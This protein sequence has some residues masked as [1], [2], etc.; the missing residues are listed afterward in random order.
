MQCLASVSIYLAFLSSWKLACEE[1]GGHHRP[2]HHA[3]EARRLD[4]AL[5]NLTKD[6]ENI[7]R[8]V[9]CIVRRIYPLLHSYIDKFTVAVPLTRTR[10]IAHRSD[11]P[12]DIKQQINHSL[13]NKLYRCAGP[14]DLE[15]SR[16][17][18]EQL[19]KGGYSQAFVDQL[20]IFHEELRDFF[21]ASSLNK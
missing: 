13:Q 16:R 1:D 21:N 12:H 10:D 6:A 3:S 8:N 20:K 4:A 7:Q 19:Q 5:S 9:P 15:T 2:N 14:E 17:V 18:L 11:I